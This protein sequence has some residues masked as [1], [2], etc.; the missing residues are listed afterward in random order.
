MSSSPRSKAPLASRLRVASPVRSASD[1]WLAVRMLLWSAALPLLKRVVPLARLARLMY[2][3]RAP[4]VDRRATERIVLITE[5][6]Y[7][8][9]VSLRDNCLE[10]SLLLYRFLSRIGAD[11]RLIVGVR[12]GRADVT[13]HVWVVVD[14]RPLDGDPTAL[15][16]FTELLVF[17]AGGRIEERRA[18]TPS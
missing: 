9:R 4:G 7:R 13:G 3:E 17:G 8:G 18:S 15:G 2:V 11:P 6:I 5:A 12:K 16:A 1:V 10:R 14:E